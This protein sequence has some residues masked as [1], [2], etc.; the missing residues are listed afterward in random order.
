MS[1]ANF[2]NNPVQP[3]NSPRRLR[4]KVF[5]RG[6]SEEDWSEAGTGHLFTGV[7][8]DEGME[9]P[10]CDEQ[11]CLHVISETDSNCLKFYLSIINLYFLCKLDRF[12]EK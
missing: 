4:V 1:P 6:P 12:S 5:V 3:A 8:E 7:E 9:A 10:V 2:Q 11:R